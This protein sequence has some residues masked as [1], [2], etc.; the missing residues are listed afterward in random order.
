MRQLTHRVTRGNRAEAVAAPKH[1]QEDCTLEKEKLMPG[2]T[3]YSSLR[4]NLA[5][6]LDEVA[7]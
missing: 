4:E 1:V 6:V 3:T 2:Q 5:S 7:D